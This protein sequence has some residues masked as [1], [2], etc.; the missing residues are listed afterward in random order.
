MRKDK[1]ENKSRPIGRKIAVSILITVL[2]PAIFVFVLLFLFKLFWVIP[3]Y[4]LAIIIAAG[5]VNRKRPEF[6]RALRKPKKPSLLD[7]P[8][9]AEFSHSSAKRRAYMM[10]VSIS[11][12]AN[13]QITINSSPFVIGRA[14]T[15]DFCIA[16]G[17]VSSRHLVIE[18]NPESKLC[19]ATDV[20]TN[21]SYLNSVRMQN[22]VR[23]PL[24]HG[25]TLQIAGLMFRVEYVHF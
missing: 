9:P 15:S 20:S 5:I 11:N 23:R 22:N 3:F 21:G 7:L 1:D 14:S 25:D 4:L 6:F 12:A 16:D 19:Y 17:Y 2:I 10:L 13:Q 24:H 18:F 8:K